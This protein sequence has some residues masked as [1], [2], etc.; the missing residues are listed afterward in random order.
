VEDGF[1]KNRGTF[2]F[3]PKLHD[4]GE[5][6]VLGQKIPA[7][8]G[9]ADGDR[10]LDIL[11][12]HPWT[13]TF[14][15]RKLVRY[16]HGREQDG[17]ENPALV[18]STATVYLRSGGDIAAMVE[19]ILTAPQTAPPIMKRPFDYVVSA[20]RATNADTDGSSGVQS[21]L[22]RMGQP[23]YEWP[24]PDG[25]PDK[26]AAWTGSLLARWNFAFALFHHDGEVAGT[27]VPFPEKVT[28]ESLTAQILGRRPDDSLVKPLLTALAAHA[29]KPTE[30]AALLLTA[31][32]FQWR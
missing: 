3:D 18:A 14:I 21:H 27:T 28:A 5:K 10:V 19:H 32:V 1:L 15:A 12:H 9:E 7:G 22:T 23:L 26:T 29:G 24:M 16:L 31:P 13:A 2:R 11:T 25:Y 17:N 6:I 8:G 30:M 20:L 4:N